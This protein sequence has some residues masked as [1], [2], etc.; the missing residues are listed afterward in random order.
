MDLKLKLTRLHVAA[1][2]GAL[3]AVALGFLLHE[4][5]MGRALVNASYDLLHVLR[6]EV[7]TDEA[8]MV[9]MDEVSYEKLGQAMNGVWD[10]SLHAKL[11]KRLTAA[12]A[13]AI[14]FDIT[15][16]DPIPANRIG[17]EALASAATNSGRVIVA[18]DN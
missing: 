2:A 18:V 9:Y 17:D 7:R 15:F 13:R 5:P 1:A 11:I 14:A 3:L 12:G 8:V 16:T 10:R 6:G 4:F